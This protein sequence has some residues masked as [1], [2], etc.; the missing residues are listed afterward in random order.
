MV[1][2][3]LAFVFALL[4]LPACRDGVIE[5]RPSEPQFGLR[6]SPT[7]DLEAVFG[8]TV[9]V[10]AYSDVTRDGSRKIDLG[11]N[12][13]VRNT[14]ADSAITINSVRYYDNDGKLLGEFLEQAQVVPAMASRTYVVAQE[15]DEGGTGANF[16]VEWTAQEKVTEPII[17]AVMVGISGTQGMTFR[18]P[19]RVVSAT[20]RNKE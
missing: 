12:L 18:S 16:I 15:H 19:G 5:Q 11:V 8:Q 17:E 1:R 4:L 2:I 10:P 9:Y 6:P 13:S 20:E 3:T 7:V 14:D